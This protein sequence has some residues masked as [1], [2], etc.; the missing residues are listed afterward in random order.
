MFGTFAGARDPP[1]VNSGEIFVRMP[2]ESHEGN[3]GNLKPPE[4]DC[5]TGGFIEFEP[6]VFGRVEV[7]LFSL[8]YSCV[9]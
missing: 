4:G 6:T 9:L 8:K 2:T 3:P 7:G 1:I 5:F